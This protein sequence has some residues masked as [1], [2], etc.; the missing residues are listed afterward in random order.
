MENQKEDITYKMSSLDKLQEDFKNVEE[1][2][3]IEITKNSEFEKE[4]LIREREI[5]RTTEDLQRCVKEKYLLEENIVNFKREN[6]ELVEVKETG[7]QRGF[8]LERQLEASQKD[9][10]Y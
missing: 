4:V 5:E 7:G 10:E 6:K 3:R 1:K 8:R 2:L 9:I